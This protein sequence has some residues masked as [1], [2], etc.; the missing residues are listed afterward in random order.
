MGTWGEAELLLGIW[1]A[2][3]N[4]FRE[5]RNIFSGI[6][7]DQCIIFRYQGST[8]PL[9]G[10]GGL[11]KDSK[12]NKTEYRSKRNPTGK[13]QSARQTAKAVGDDALQIGI[14]IEFHCLGAVYEYDLS[15]KEERDLGT[16]N[17]PSTDDRS[18]RL[19]V[20]TLYDNGFQTL[21]SLNS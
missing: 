12:V 19:W 1:G 18:V 3:Q 10:G 16:V 11:N 8:D 2:R 9:G 7:G 13:S 21:A 20:Q 4:N 6:W 17:A 5:R 15:N 14:G